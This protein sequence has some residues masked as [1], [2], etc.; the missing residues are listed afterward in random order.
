MYKAL[1]LTGLTASQACADDGEMNRWAS[2]AANPVP[3]GAK[4]TLRTDRNEYFLGE[5]V[6]LVFILENTGNEPF[7][8]EF[9][10]DYRGSS[11][12]LRFIVTAT[13]EAGQLAEDPDRSKMCLGGL[14][15]PREIKPGTNYTQSLPLMRY[16][17][18]GK[19]GR[20]TIRAAHDFGW[21]E[22]GERKRPVGETTLT[23]REPTPD[24]AAAVVDA[25]LNTDAADFTLLTHPVYFTPLLR[26][27]K[28]GNHR[29]LLGVGCMA[30]REAT[31]ALI[32]FTAS[33]N[34]EIALA[35]TQLVL[36]RLPPPINERQSFWN[37]PPFTREFRQHLA[38]NAW[39]DAFAPALRAWAA[40]LLGRPPIGIN[41]MDWLAG[42]SRLQCVFPFIPQERQE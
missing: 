25:L 11:R 9:G 26:H 28:T 20:Y 8:A 29:A 15:G 35:A 3:D 33:D 2:H 31:E 39:D 24:E 37:G 22:D 18:V 42:C 5:D 1:L 17:R 10:G 34:P 41:I 7:S 16:C 6:T 14:M 19:P 23:F 21:K 27:A 30:T 40:D 38:E 4:V 32:A 13:D 12:S 36:M